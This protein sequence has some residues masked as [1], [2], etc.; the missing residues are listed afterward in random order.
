MAGHEVTVYEKDNKAGGLLR[1][2]IPDFKLEKHIIDRRLDLYVGEGIKFVTGVTVG[3]DIKAADLL[4]S[5]DSVCLACGSG[6]PRDLKIEGRDLEG[7]H[8]AMEYLAQSNRRISGE[9][10]GDEKLIDAAGKRVVV[11]GG[12]DT[13]SDCIGTAN[14]QGAAKVTQLELLPM[15]PGERP[16]KYPW[17][18]YPMILK[19][20]TSHEEGADRQWGVSTVKFA[21]DKTVKSLRCV[22]VDKD[23]RE[24]KGSNF[25]IDADLVLL[26]IGF[27]GPVYKGLIEDMGLERDG[28]GNVKTGNDFMTGIKNVFCAGDMRRG[29]SLIVWAISEGRKAAHFID[30]NLMGRTGLPVI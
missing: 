16:E 2:G 24:I 25:S 17:P 14:R 4:T 3:K 12:G 1:Y 15:P 6:E 22:K 21:G 5:F 19:Q 10:T 28:R 30:L 8:F 9:N 23:C 29:Q 13:G 18:L 7:I 11:I 27:A 20:T 26:A